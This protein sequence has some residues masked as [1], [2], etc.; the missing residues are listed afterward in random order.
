VTLRRFTINLAKRGPV[1]Q[2]LKW[3]SEKVIE[4][5]IESCSIPRTAAIGRGEAC[6]V[7]R[8]EPMHDSVPYL[9]NSL[10]GETDI[11]HEYFI[12]REH[13]VAFIDD[14]REI[15]KKHD[16]NLLNASVRAAHADDTLLSYAPRDAFALVLYINQRTTPEGNEN[17][18]ALTSDLIDASTRHG[19]RFF[20]PYQLH[21]A[22][23]QL[24]AAYPNFAAFAAY[25]KRIDPQG[26]LTNT[27]WEKY[28]A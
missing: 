26:V 18:R 19:G 11:L 4:P 28:G 15:L 3:W 16:A 25:K 1:W 2:R 6:L 21:Y 17:M 14:A 13:I 8:N 24:R 9:K 22:A 10:K 23:D 5:T 12:P 20:L 27:W 7:S